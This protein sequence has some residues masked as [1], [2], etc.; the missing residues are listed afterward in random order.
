MKLSYKSLYDHVFIRFRRRRMQRFYDL[1]A[2][3]ATT[4]P[5]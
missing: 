1:L 2:P 3:S 4:S 5:S